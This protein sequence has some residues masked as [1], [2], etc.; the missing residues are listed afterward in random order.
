MYAQHGLHSYPKSIEKEKLCYKIQFKY[1]TINANIFLT[2]CYGYIKMQK[3]MWIIIP[4]EKQN[5]ILVKE[6]RMLKLSMKVQYKLY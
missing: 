1:N 3:F 5:I 2:T 6:Y 4:H